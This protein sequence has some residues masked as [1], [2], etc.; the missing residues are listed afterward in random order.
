MALF[1]IIFLSSTIGYFA[2]MKKQFSTIRLIDSWFLYILILTSAIPSFSLLGLVA[3]ERV[4]YG[5]NKLLDTMWPSYCVN[6]RFQWFAS[7]ANAM[8]IYWY[9]VSP[10]FI[11]C[12]WTNDQDTI[13]LHFAGAKMISGLSSS[14]LFLFDVW[15]LFNAV[16]YRL[17][18]LFLRYG[19]QSLGYGEV[20]SFE[21]TFYSIL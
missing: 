3:N 1:F 19:R 9:I 18:Y 4:V 6:V 20:G 8:S 21:V 12:F 11:K 5:D 15:H 17:F 10:A 14:L 2:Y 16:W 13:V 7:V